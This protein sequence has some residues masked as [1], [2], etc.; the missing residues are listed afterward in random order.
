[1]TC[2]DIHI[3][4]YTYIKRV[5]ELS[6]CVCLIY[7]CYFFKYYHSYLITFFG[8]KLIGCIQEKGLTFLLLKTNENTY[9]AHV[10]LPIL[11]L[12]QYMREKISEL[13]I[14]PTPTALT[15]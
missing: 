6:D 12:G 15:I 10:P 11:I 1:M 5:K 3:H 9:L 4:T 13:P 7:P 2:L 14:V 8:N